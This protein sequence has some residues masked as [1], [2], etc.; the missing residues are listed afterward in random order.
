MMNN[1]NATIHVHIKMRWLW[2]YR[3]WTIKFVS[4]FSKKKAQKELS[5]F[6]KE[7]EDIKKFVNITYIRK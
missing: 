4:F 2:H 5:K 1:E 6:I 7:M 3:I